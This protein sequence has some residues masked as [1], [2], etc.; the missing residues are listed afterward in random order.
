MNNTIP[1]KTVLFAIGQTTVDVIQTYTN[2]PVVS[3]EL[4]GKEHIIEEVITYFDT[5]KHYE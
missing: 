2:N 4:P 5:I 1:T 3:G